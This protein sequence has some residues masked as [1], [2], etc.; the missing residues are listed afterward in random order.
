MAAKKDPIFTFENLTSRGIDKVPVNNTI[1]VI[2]SDGL[3]NSIQVV[4]IS[5]A[6]MMFTSTIADFLANNDL[7]NEL[8][9]RVDIDGGTF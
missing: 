9:Q 3:G 7:Y 5:N 8:Q 1:L 4:K 2:N 6:G